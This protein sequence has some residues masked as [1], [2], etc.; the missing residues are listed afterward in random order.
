MPKEE[1]MTLPADLAGMITQER[2]EGRDE[3]LGT[4]NITQDDILIPRLAIA[5]KTSK[6]LEDGNPRFIEGIRFPEMFNSVTRAVYGKGPLHFVIL[7]VDR[8]RGVQFRSLEEGGGIIDPNVP[9]DDPR[10]QFGGIDP[11]TGKAE[12]P[13]ATKFYDFIILLLTN[14][15]MRDPVSNIVALSCKSTAIKA[16]KT[17][18]ML[19]TQRGKK[20]LY[21]GVYEISTAIDQ[22]SMGAFGVYKIRNAGWLPAGSPAE[23]MAAEMYEAWK[24]RKAVIDVDA[25]PDGFD[26]AA[27][28]RQPMPTTGADEHGM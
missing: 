2:P 9:L 11:T 8:P 10:M 12:K 17:L 4:D 18:N 19:I 23:A 22:N 6:E 27:L 7:R 21:K 26:P 16:A 1:L 28:D 15:D 20:A 3:D 13:I 25:D 5:Q 14:I 24:A